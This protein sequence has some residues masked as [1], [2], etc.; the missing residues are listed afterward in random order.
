MC[1]SVGYSRIFFWLQIQYG[2]YLA[3]DRPGPLVVIPPAR[4]G[5]DANGGPADVGLAAQA[6][7]GV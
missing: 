6:P 4:K 2:G 7:Q 3:R 5:P 1:G